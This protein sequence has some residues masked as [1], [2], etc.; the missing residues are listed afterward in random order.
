MHI[1]ILIFM[2]IKIKNSERERKI[3]KHTLIYSK[4]LFKCSKFMVI[5]FVHT[6][7]IELIRNKKKGE[8][9]EE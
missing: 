2:Q 6:K 8:E 5:V 4:L 3:S 9:K 7:S 1:N